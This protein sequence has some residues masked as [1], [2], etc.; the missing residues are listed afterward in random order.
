MDGFP[1]LFKFSMAQATLIERLSV[2]GVEY[3]AKTI[4]P[5]RYAER[6]YQMLYEHDQAMREAAKDT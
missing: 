3:N 1:E 2:L 5:E 4:S 6:V